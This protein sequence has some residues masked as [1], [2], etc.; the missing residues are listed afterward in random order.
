M[1]WYVVTAPGH[2][3]VPAMRVAASS[4][5]M[6]AEHFTEQRHEAIG[7]HPIHEVQV[8]PEDGGPTDTFRV[9]MR[10]MMRAAARLAV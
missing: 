3:N 1:T 7:S 2:P 10:M 9:S 8:R 4:P 6:A 5:H